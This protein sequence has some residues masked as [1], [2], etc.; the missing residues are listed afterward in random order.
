MLERYETLPV[1]RAK[2]EAIYGYVITDI[3]RRRIVEHC[4]SEVFAEYRCLILN[5]GPVC[6]F[7]S[8]EPIA[9]VLHVVK[10]VRNESNRIVA[11]FDN[12]YPACVICA[13]FDND[14]YC[15]WFG[16]EVQKTTPYQQ[17]E[18]SEMYKQLVNWL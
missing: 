9:F 2:G 18:L 1:T 7:C 5:D 15:S 3:E 8:I 10:Q 12:F 17:A 16:V 6:H 14:W 13:S 4:E 11:M